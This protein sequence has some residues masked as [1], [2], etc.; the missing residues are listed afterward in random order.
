M[1]AHQGRTKQRR[2]KRR[3][4]CQKHAAKKKK[5]VICDTL[6]SSNVVPTVARNK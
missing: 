3:K 1:R 6:L 2:K 4:I 5:D